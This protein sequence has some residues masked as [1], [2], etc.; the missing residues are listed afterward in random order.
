[1]ELWPGENDVINIP[2]SSGISTLNLNTFQLV[3]HLL[4]D[5]SSNLLSLSI[6]SNKLF[7]LPVPSWTQPP[8]ILFFPFLWFLNIL[9]TRKSHDCQPFSLTILQKAFLLG[10]LHFISL[11][12]LFLWDWI[13][14]QDYFLC[15]LRPWNYIWPV[16]TLGPLSYPKIRFNFPTILYKTI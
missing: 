14:D 2:W 12:T 9:H 11:I 10:R 16:L 6:T 1:M 5:S 15:F 7:L 3:S 8:F 4:L 13:L